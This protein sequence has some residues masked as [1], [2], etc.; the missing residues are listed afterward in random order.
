MPIRGPPGVSAA[1]SLIVLQQQRTSYVL[2]D[3]SVSEKCH[4]HVVLEKSHDTETLPRAR[5]QIE[6]D[7]NFRCHMDKNMYSKENCSLRVGQI[8]IHKLLVQFGY[9]LLHN[10]PFC[11]HIK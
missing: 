3:A 1:M 11:L 2:Q 8:S 9:I 10:G 7:K 5:L 6:E 4:I